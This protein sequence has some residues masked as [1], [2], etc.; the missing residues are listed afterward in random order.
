MGSTGA[1]PLES[2]AYRAFKGIKGLDGLL[3]Q[4][5]FL[6]SIQ[7][8]QIAKLAAQERVPA[9]YENRAQ[10]GR[11]DVVWRRFARKLPAGSSLC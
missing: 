11:A 10:V 2:A 1:I 9:S 5:D 3:V 6:F 4:R 8:R 7:S